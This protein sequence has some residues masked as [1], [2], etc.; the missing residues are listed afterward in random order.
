MAVFPDGRF[1]NNRPEAPRCQL[2]VGGD[3]EQEP[4]VASERL[5]QRLLT[6]DEK[7]VFSVSVFVRHRVVTHS[8]CDLL[9]ATK[10]VAIHPHTGKLIQLHNSELEL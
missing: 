9:Q 2:T 5:G 8:D 3:R 6:V 7:P 10:C 1:Y 4:G